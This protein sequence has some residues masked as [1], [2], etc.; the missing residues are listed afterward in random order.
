MLNHTGTVMIETKRLVLRRFV[1]SDAEPMFKNW[2]NDERVTGFLTWTP[3]GELEN[4]KALL[5]MWESAYKDPENY[6]W[7]ITLDGEPIGSIGVVNIGSRNENC[8]IG[9]CLSHD[10]WGLGIMP[11][12]LEG[13]INHL[14]A[15]VGF[16]RITAKHAV[17]NAKSGRV[18]QKCGMSLEGTMRE[19]WKTHSGEFHDLNLYA[20]LKRDWAKGWLKN[21]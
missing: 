16:H 10:F 19:G 4:T 2:A 8:E 17:K 13:V 20:I 7:C 6:N 21:N 15:H 11:E 5:E 12:A 3:H 9:Y 18:M 1:P 14:F